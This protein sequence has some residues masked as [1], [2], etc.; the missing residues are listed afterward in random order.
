MWRYK[1]TKEVKKDL[2][3]EYVNLINREIDIKKELTEIQRKKI[4]VFRKCM[5]LGIPLRNNFG[6]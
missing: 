6:E 2:K 5:V 4:E 3:S 1:K